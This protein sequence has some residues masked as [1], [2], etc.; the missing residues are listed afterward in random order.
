MNGLPT[1]TDFSPFIGRTIDMMRMG[2][3]QLHYF[4]NHARPD[5]PDVWI[6]I[7]SNKLI[8]TDDKGRPA[9]I[10]DFRTGGG[11]LC[12]LLGLT[13]EKASRSDSGGLILGMS[14]GVRLEVTIHTS[15]YESVVL[16]VGDRVIV[17]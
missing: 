10:N 2:K 14:T 1:T 15:M 11:L 4:L 13:I 9:D 6:E 16:H 8:F 5:K 17:G 12:L 3:Y 7:E